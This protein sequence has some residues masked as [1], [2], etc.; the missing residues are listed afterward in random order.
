[1]ERK[2]F[3][4]RHCN[5][6]IEWAD[7]LYRTG[8]A[9]DTERARELYKAVIFAH[10]FDPGVSPKWGKPE[11]IFMQMSINPAVSSQLARAWKGFTQIEVGLNYYGATDSY[12]PPLRY[13]VLKE[14]ADRFAAAAKSASQDFI[15]SVSK[16]EEAVPDGIMTANMLKKASLQAEI[17]GEQI[18]IAKVG[19][20]NASA[21][22][23][24]VKNAIDKKKKELEDHQA[25]G[26]QFLDFW[27]RICRC[28]RVASVRGDQGS[29]RERR[30]GTVSAAR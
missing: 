2:F 9:A 20:K 7:A 3:R 19:V 21:Q 8:A 16:I 24:S 14:A 10:G 23:Q 11:F 17:A 1:M 5:A 13:H 30:G 18:D 27:Q 15:T 4:L 25:F 26:Q 12:V 28:D 22:V 6:M 29:R